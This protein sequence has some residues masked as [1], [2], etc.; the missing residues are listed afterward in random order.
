MF[1]TFKNVGIDHDVRNVDSFRPQLLREHL[2]ERTLSELPNGEV[3]VT[4]TPDQG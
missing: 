4:G 2:R 3:Q 1:L